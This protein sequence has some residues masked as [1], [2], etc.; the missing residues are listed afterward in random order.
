VGGLIIP[1]KPSLSLCAALIIFAMETSL[2]RAHYTG[3][4][5]SPGK[6]KDDEMMAYM[7]FG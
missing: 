1:W 7:N 2:S 4:Q 5:L 6:D 3:Y